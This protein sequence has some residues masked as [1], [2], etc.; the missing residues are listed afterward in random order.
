MR[1][2][3]KLCKSMNKINE[4]TYCYGKNFA[5]VIDGQSSVN[6]ENAKITKWYVNVLKRELKKNINDGNLLD[7]LN[8]TI[9]SASST[10]KKTFSKTSVPSATAAIIRQNN[11]KVEILIVGNAKCLVQ[12]KKIELVEDPRMDRVED[13]VLK[14]AKMLY[15]ENNFNMDELKNKFYELLTESRK[16]VNTMGGYPVIKDKVLSKEDV[17]YKE[18]DYNDVISAVICTDGFYAYKTYLMV[19]DEDLYTIINNQGLSH[20]Y[21]HITRMESKDVN[22]S[23]FPRLKLY[24]DA[25]ALYIVFY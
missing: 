25:S 22:C 1:I 19:K 17:V 18:Y 16:K 3:D 12:T 6:D 9:K 11:S 10:F 13:N 14:K 23:S 21:K 2:T 8:Q 20:C 5:F 24:D 4:D 15:S 7:V